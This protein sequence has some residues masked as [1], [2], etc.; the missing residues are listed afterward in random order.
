MSKKQVKKPVDG[1]EAM[2]AE[3]PI[4]DI[5]GK[6]YQMKRLGIQETF[7]FGNLLMDILFS[8]AGAITK[9]FDQTVVISLMVRAL[10]EKEKELLDLFA[11]LLGVSKKDI[12]N[13]DLFPM[14]SEIA[15]IH[16]LVAHP[17][18]GRFFTTFRAMLDDPR[19]TN[20]VGQ[21]GSML[22]SNATDGET[23]TS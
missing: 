6:Q 2:T 10:M 8:S 1:I 19:L 7:R 22:S 5:D 9:D 15:I 12:R 18:I 3:A 13:P 14:G 21:M 17:D 23:A 4:V 20:M 11:D 16:A